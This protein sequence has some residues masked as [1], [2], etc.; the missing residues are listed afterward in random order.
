MKTKLDKFFKSLCLFADIINNL[1]FL[2]INIRQYSLDHS[3]VDNNLMNNINNFKSLK[4]IVLVGFN[5]KKEFILSIPSL[6]GIKLVICH[7]ID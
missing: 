6:K 1:E 3:Q 5:F 7:N 4:Q 2:H